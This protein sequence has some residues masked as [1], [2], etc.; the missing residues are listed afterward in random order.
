MGFKKK[1]LVSM[2]TRVL[3]ENKKL[4]SSI[5]ANKIVKRNNILNILII[6]IICMNLFKLQA[7]QT[8]L[9]FDFIKLLKQQ[10][11]HKHTI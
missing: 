2:T 11:K 7:V 1:Q 3:L 10:A 9:L 8:P 6:Y 4:R 5:F